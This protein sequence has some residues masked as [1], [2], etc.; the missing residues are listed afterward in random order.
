MSLTHMWIAA[1]A[2]GVGSV[3]A[4]LRNLTA[5][6]PLEWGVYDFFLIRCL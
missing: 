3:T 4:L 2:Q 1:G 6:H 5:G